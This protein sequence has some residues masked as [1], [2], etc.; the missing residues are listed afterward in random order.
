MN[1]QFGIALSAMDIDLNSQKCTTDL[2]DNQEKIGRS[3][4]ISWSKNVN[5]NNKDIEIW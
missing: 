3:L 4:V 1:N 2:H 5:E